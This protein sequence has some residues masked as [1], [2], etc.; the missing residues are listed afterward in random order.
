[1]SFSKNT[2]SSKRH[3]INYMIK[4]NNKRQ[5][6]K[7]FNAGFGFFNAVFDPITK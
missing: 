5:D 7:I 3:G 4:Y 6:M 1:M 2:E